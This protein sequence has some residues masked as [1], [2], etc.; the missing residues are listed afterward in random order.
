MGSNAIITFK[1]M[2]ES[3][4]VDLE[5]VKTEVLKIAQEQGAKGEMRATIEPLAFGLKQLMLMAMYEVNDD[6]D[7]DTIAEKFAVLD[8]VQTSEVAKMDLAM[9]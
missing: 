5:A 2:P 7:F 3:P 9:G 8:G 1:I 6:V 4:D